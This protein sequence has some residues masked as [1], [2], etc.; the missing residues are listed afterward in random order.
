MGFVAV[1]AFAVPRAAWGADVVT[2]PLEGGPPGPHRI[3]AAI[4]YAS[5]DGNKD[6]EGDHRV[7]EH[8]GSFRAAYT[9]RLVKGFEFGGNLSYWTSEGSGI[10]AFLPSAHIR[11]F[12]PIADVVEIGL[13]A[14]AG[15]C[16]W[17]QS[18]QGTGAWVGPALSAGPD[19]RVWLTRDL[20]LEI[21]GDVTIA[22]GTGPEQPNLVSRTAGFM[23]A[24]VFAGAL[25]RL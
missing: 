14:R 17:P 3:S 1:A 21:A 8:A 12:I 9:Y 2:G 5:A 23:A 11:P 20:G 4:G 18:G 15:V 13:T 25:Y 16:I 19:V 6:I 7:A 24:G 10:N 22:G